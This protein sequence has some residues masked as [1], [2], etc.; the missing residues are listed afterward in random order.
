MVEGKD[1]SRT[2]LSLTI[3]IV[4]ATVLFVLLFESDA[5]PHLGS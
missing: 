5:S 4:D 1:P 3:S 2:M